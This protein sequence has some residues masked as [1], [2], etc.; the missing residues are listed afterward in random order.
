MGSTELE[1]LCQKAMMYYY[2]IISDNTSEIPSG[3]QKHIDQCRHCKQ[4]ISWLSQTDRETRSG[5]QNTVIAAHVTHLELH[6]ALADHPVSC[7]TIK[8]YLPALAADPT[9]TTAT[10]VTAHIKHCCRCAEDLAA[11]RQ[12]NLTTAQYSDIC[13]LFSAG[14]KPL[15]LSFSEVQTRTIRE[16]QTRADSGVVTRFRIKDSSSSNEPAAFD[17]EVVRASTTPD[18][19][20]R[21]PV[22]IVSVAGQNSGRHFHFQPQ[23]LI[24]PIAAAAA[25]LICTFLLFKGSTVQATDI[26]Q[27]YDALK[28]VKNIV[29]TYYTA[30][31]DSP[32]QEIRV[33]KDMRVKLSK[34]G[35]TLTLWNLNQKVRQTLTNTAPLQ[36]SQLDDAEIDAASK[37]INIPF[38]LLPFKN[39]RELPKGAIWKKTDLVESD[40]AAQSVEAYDLFWTDQGKACRWQCRIDALTKR[41][42]YILYWEKNPA[43]MDYELVNRIEVSYPTAEQ[44]KEAIRPFG[45]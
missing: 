8:S 18:C 13:R 26:S 27:I 37:T 15:W 5:N 36:T 32:I 11:L 42:Q 10:P 22:K 45:L 30:E 20:E 24:R 12:M 40:M 19:Q 14:Q 9:V 38:G 44:T 17:V 2:D 4:E 29:M 23:R 43:D 1:S 31:S 3:I 28:D 21:Q 39:T 34:I 41:P 16:I 35:E 33:S 25:I 7:S 6:F